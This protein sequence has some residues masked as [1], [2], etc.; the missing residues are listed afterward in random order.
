[1][2]KKK[3]KYVFWVGIDEYG[4]DRFVWQGE[5]IAYNV[6]HARKLLSAFKKKFK[7]QIDVE[8]GKISIFQEGLPRDEW[9]LAKP[10]DK[11]GSVK[12]G[13]L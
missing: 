1:M 6:S 4:H 8:L 12:G 7:K 5:L 3:Q 2:A 11:I 10:S 9:N 13:T